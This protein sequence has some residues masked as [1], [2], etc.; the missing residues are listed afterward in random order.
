[1]KDLSEKQIRIKSIIQKQGF[2]PH[3]GLANQ[4]LARKGRV[5][6]IKKLELQSSKGFAGKT[7]P[8]GSVFGNI[9][10]EKRL[11]SPSRQKQRYV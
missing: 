10:L 2:K 5:A 11:P 9:S 6:M 4:S 8:E 7:N 3:I 1:M